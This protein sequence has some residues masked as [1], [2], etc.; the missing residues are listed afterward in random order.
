MQDFQYKAFNELFD[1]SGKTAIVTGGANGIGKATALRLAQAGAN[2]VIA[3]LKLEDAKAA[4]KDI[5]EYGVRGFAIECNILKDDD[6]V[7]MVEKVVAEFGSINILINNAGGG[8]GGREN[9]TK[10]SVDDIRR[11]FELNVF[12]G[13]RLS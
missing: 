9:P 3:D 5:E 1:L 10:I 7:N 12:S 13:W 11:D 4:V 2:I 8:G 6:L